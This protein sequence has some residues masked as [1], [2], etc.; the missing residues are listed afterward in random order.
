MSAE[1]AFGMARPPRRINAARLA[2]LQ[3]LGNPAILF[4][5]NML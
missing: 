5:K 4:G 1:Y 3:V 2:H